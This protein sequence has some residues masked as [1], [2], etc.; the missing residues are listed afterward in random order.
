MKKE[1]VEDRTQH[2]NVHIQISYIHNYRVMQS[3]SSRDALVTLFIISAYR[4]LLVSRSQT[5]T[6]RGTESGTLTICEQF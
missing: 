4:A 2:V 6:S 3:T 5:L 1:E